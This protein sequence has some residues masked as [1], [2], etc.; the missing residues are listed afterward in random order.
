ME[1]EAFVLHN[2]HF[3]V[4]CIAEITSSEDFH[5]FFSKTDSK[6]SHPFPIPCALSH[7]LSA[8]KGGKG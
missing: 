6:A 5:A 4:F 1:N 7:R 3:M 2:V 8:R